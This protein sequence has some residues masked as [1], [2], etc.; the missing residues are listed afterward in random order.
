M[1][2]QKHNIGYNDDLVMSFGIGLYVRD[3]AL[4]FKQ[5]GLDIT[6]AALGSFSK[7]PLTI[8]SWGLFLYRKR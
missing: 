5:H 3:T 6:K 2:E 1:V 8:L 7:K 4:K